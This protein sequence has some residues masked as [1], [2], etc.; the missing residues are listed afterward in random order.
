M[1]LKGKGVATR[2]TALLRLTDVQRFN[3]LLGR[4]SKPYW[5][6]ILGLIVLTYIGTFL[7]MLSPLILA[8]VLHIV[9]G[10]PLG[11]EE[12]ISITF[13]NLNLDNLGPAMFQWLGLGRI[14]NLFHAVVA[15]ALLYIGVGILKNVIEFAN[16]LLALWINVRARRDLQSDL[17]KH[18]LSLSMEFFT[19]QRAGELVS[20][21][22]SDTVATTTGL[23][24]IVG[25]VL[26][27]PV[28][29]VFYG[30]LLFNTSKK[31][32]II[33]FVA[34][35]FHY[36]ITRGIRNP[37]R[38]RLTDQFSALGEWLVTLQE[39]IMN[40]RAVKGFC[41][42]K[43]EYRRHQEVTQTL[44]RINMKYGIFKH[45]EEPA[46]G[47]VG[48][49]IEGLVI[50][51]AAFELMSG[52]LSVST[53]FLFLYIGRAIM[54]PIATLAGT[55]TQIQSSLAASSRLF[56]LFA[57]RPKVADGH[58]HISEFS[59]QLEFRNVSFAYG[60]QKVLENISFNILKGEMV[61]LVGQSGVGKST[62][63]DLMMRFYDP[64]EGGIFIDGHNIRTLKQTSYR[65]LFG[66]VPQ[67][68]MLFNTTIRENIAYGH[69]WVSGDEI[70]EAAKVANA[71]EFIME[72]PRR[73]ETLVGDRGIRLSGGQRQR[74][75]IARAI[76]G[77]PQILI[78]DE[79]TSSLDS[80]S[81][82]LVQSAI[83]R[84]IKGATAVVIAHRLSTIMNADKIVILGDGRVEAV[85]RHDD[86]LKTESSYEKLYRLQLGALE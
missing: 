10:K 26:T 76:I 3:F 8:P 33:A 72:L 12:N 73:Y 55:M 68:P 15:L 51:L 41:A 45:I 25:K 4:Y 86:L 77:N 22:S 57:E 82:R 70:V 43:F 56:E 65:K 78:M 19:R 13:S 49:I 58:D 66:A 34:A 63:A 36:G 83:D 64:N 37:I 5:K 84:V 52:R 7:T 6:S 44:T 67:E 23:D 16:Y 54:Q 71:H 48:Y 61:A 50:I 2:A 74:V 1:S 30:L 21:I 20:R 47:I 40:I 62:L 9:L 80:E 46:R 14:G 81:E 17:F 75:A 29:I 38:R 69:E 79:A 39:A 24:T 42:E 60:D 11:G 35:V 28:L 31:L 32:A 27:S 53:F 85:G 59:D 18:I